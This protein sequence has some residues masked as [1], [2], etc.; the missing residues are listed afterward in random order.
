MARGF[1]KI[2][3]TGN[4]GADPET[5]TFDSGNS[6]TKFPVAVSESYKNR[7]G[8]TVQETEWFNVVVW[9]KLAEVCEKYLEKG[10]QVLIEG[11]IK[12]RTYEDQNGDTKRFTELVA[13]N[14][15]M[16]GGSHNES[17]GGDASDGNV[18]QND[19]K[20]SKSDGNPYQEQEDDLPF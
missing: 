7:D 6:V 17:S 2:I 12:T 4:L 13:S 18:S 19:G 16:M 1:Q 5:K 14:L 10:N 3:I 9:G 20:S 8:E 11:K 15:N